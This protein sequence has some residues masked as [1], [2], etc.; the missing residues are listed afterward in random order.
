MPNAEFGG[1]FDPEL[2]PLDPARNAANRRASYADRIGRHLSRDPSGSQARLRRGTEHAERAIE[3]RR[4]WP[5]ILSCMP[6][7]YAVLWVARLRENPNA[8]DALSPRGR[9]GSRMVKALHI[10]LEAVGI[11]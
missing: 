1:Q 4:N 8:D 9:I 10:A 3:L 7:K 2:I 5:A 11:E 6:H